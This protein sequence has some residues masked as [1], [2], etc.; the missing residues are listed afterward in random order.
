MTFWE[1]LGEREVFRL[2]SGPDKEMVRPGRFELP[3]HAV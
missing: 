3:N 2:F 1:N